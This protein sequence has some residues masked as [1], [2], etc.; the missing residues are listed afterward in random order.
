[1][2]FIKPVPNHWRPDDFDLSNAVLD[3]AVLHIT[4]TVCLLESRCD[5]YA[6]Y[7]RAIFLGREAAWNNAIDQ[8]NFEECQHGVVLRRLSESVD[9]DF[10]FDPTMAHY[11]SLVS[12]HEP[13]GESVRGSVGAEMVSRCVVEALA[14]TLYRVLAD[15][16]D[17]PRCRSVY[18]S[19]AQD[20]ARHFGMF[21]KMLD[22]ESAANR[23]LGTLARSRYSLQRILQL[24]DSQITIASCVVAG[25]AE[26][27]I[28]QRRE[29]NDYLAQLY[30]LYRWKHL[31]Y[32]VKMLLHTIAITP[33]PAVVIAGTLVLWCGL[34]TRYYGAEFCR[35][36]FS[37]GLQ[38]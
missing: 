25:R 32:A 6:E 28:Q 18:T 3:A 7:L 11:E 29:A 9:S 19:L 1:M 34:R 13:T 36:F 17:D 24:E 10:C 38:R 2:R 5:D 20:E 37:P 8:W 27:A 15:A 31:R 22:T 21:L 30:S 12:Y 16:T 14:S 4:K 35:R 26:G 33:R 23:G